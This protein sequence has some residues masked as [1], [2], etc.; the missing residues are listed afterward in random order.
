MG[1]QGHKSIETLPIWLLP[2][3]GPV[4]ALQGTHHLALRSAHGNDLARVN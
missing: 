3:G 2:D 4:G 1:S